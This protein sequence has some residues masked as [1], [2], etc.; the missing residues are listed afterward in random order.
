M[1]FSQ[2]YYAIPY[3]LL[4]GSISVYFYDVHIGLIYEDKI[5]IFIEKLSIIFFKNIIH[6]DLRLWV[7]YK[8]LLK[9]KKRKNILIPDFIHNEKNIV[10]KYN[11]RIK[12]AIVGWVDDKFVKVDKSIKILANLGVEIYFFTSKKCFDLSTKD[13]IQEKKVMKKIYYVG[14]LDSVNLENYL[15]DFSIGLCPHDAKSPL[16]S[17][18]YRKYCSS[19]RV[20]DYIQNSLTIFLSDKTIFQRFINKKYNANY[21]NINDLRSIQSI[22]ELK[23]KILI[24]DITYNNSIF[25]KK[26]LSIKLSN[27]LTLN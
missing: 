12:C 23:E 18:N 17:N 24:K 21:H 9:K 10:K 14:Y 25:N 20:I 1:I 19:M 6:R 2:P 5:K 27:F 4:G 7:E 8:H 11:D 26:K 13:L 15:E 22:D 3:F 16:L